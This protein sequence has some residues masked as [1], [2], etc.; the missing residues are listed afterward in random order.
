MILKRF[1][2]S[3]ETANAGTNTVNSALD[4]IKIDLKQKEEEIAGLE[5]EANLFSS[6]R[7]RLEFLL[8]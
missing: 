5:K 6:T 3:K 4:A 7:S 8:K 1:F 2:K